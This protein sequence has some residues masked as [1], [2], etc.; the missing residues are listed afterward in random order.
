MPA[1]CWSLPGVRQGD[2]SIAPAFMQLHHS[3]NRPQ[4]WGAAAHSVAAAPQQHSSRQVFTAQKAAQQAKMPKQH[5]QGP[6][7][8]AAL[9][10][11]ADMPMGGGAW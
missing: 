3:P 11:A 5:A 8:A 7:A 6:A 4:P 10:L 9:L 2:G 1:A